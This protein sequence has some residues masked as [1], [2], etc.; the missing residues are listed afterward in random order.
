MPYLRDRPLRARLPARRCGAVPWRQLSL[1]APLP[2]EQAGRLEQRLNAEESGPL[3]K[4][5]SPEELNSRIEEVLAALPP[6]QAIAVCLMLLQVLAVVW[7]R[8]RAGCAAPAASCEP[9]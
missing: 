4:R 7:Q 9:E 5:E 8:L 2:R 6:S 3:S 1:A